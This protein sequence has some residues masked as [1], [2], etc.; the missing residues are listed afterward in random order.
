M[1]YVGFFDGACEPRNPGGVGTYGFVLYRNGDIVFEKYG[2]AGTPWSL[3]TTNNTSEYT[4][5]IELLTYLLQNKIDTA[6][7]KGDS[8][9]V[10]KQLTGDY[11]VNSPN[12][13]PLY[14]KALALSNQLNIKYSWVP[15]EKNTY[16]DKLSKQAFWDYCVLSKADKVQEVDIKALGGNVFLANNKY[17]VDLN[18]NTCECMDYKKHNH[19]NNRVKIPCKHLIAAVNFNQKQKQEAN[20]EHFVNY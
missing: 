2:L 16:A 3:T 6:M 7:V 9:L 11:S 4:A 12:I 8:Q 14:N 18:K 13:I 15:R 10:I 5:V 20:N 17:K 19:A 1:E